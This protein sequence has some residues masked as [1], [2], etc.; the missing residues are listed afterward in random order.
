M[1]ED[2]DE[3]EDDFERNADEENALFDEDQDAPM[4]QDLF[5]SNYGDEELPGLRAQSNE[6]SIM[7]PD[8]L[9]DLDGDGEDLEVSDGSTH[10]KDMK[11][12]DED[13]SEPDLDEYKTEEEEEYG[14]Y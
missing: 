14:S 11:A 4:L 10:K 9:I 2:E 7:A 12:D 5:S 3:D 1:D 8:F 6:D 13:I